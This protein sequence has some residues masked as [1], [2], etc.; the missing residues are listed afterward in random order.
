MNI[1]KMEKVRDSNMELFRIIAMILVMIDHAG[2]LS[3]GVP[4]KYDSII[5]PI[6]VV[7]RFFTQSISVVCVNLFVLL[8]GWYGIR[9][10]KLK[11]FEL[12]F[13]VLFFSVLVYCLFLFFNFKTYFN[14]DKAGTILLIHPSD[15]WFVKSYL[16]LILLTPALNLFVEKVDVRIFRNVL[17]AFF[18][19]QFIYGWLFLYGIQDF[20]GGYSV[21][22]FAGLYMLSRYL[23]LYPIK[24]LQFNIGIYFILFF[25]VS[26]FIT[27]LS[28][29]LTRL[30]YCITG[31]LFTYTSPFIIFES[32]LLLLAFSKMKFKNNVINWIA[33]SCLAVY[34]LH[35]NELFLRPFYGKIIRNWYFND[36]TI[37]FFI[38]TIGFITILFVISILIDKVRIYIWNR[39]NRKFI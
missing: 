19:L 1:T 5:E 20:Q 2:F 10:K 28:F 16:L 17:I 15:Y 32:I 23:R 18:S 31:R 30:G 39:I 25:I 38:H 7:S 14:I 13:Q 26:L 4:C 21:V 36:N 33:S 9:I 24:K 34:L 22:S 11:L 29:L 37:Y 8:S 6:G 35:S 12:I 3:L 27:F